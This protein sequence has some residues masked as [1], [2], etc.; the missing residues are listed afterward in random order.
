M[1]S[2][3]LT[4]DQFKTI[5]GYSSK[6]SVA[7][8][9]GMVDALLTEHGVQNK[10]WITKGGVDQLLFEL[11]VEIHG[12]KRVL[13]FKFQPTMIFV[14]KKKGGRYGPIELVEKPTASW[15]V[16]HDLLQR[17]LA[18]ARLGMMPIHHILMSFIVKSL[19]DGTE[20]TFGDFMDLVLE[21]QPGLEGLQLEY[22]KNPKIIEA[23]V[24]E[25]T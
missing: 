9:K 5:P 23:E 1:K 24:T 11:D 15:R 14:K 21:R 18:A 6:L 3:E 4:M 7:R 2:V 20:G 16:F 19:P 22:K 12:V 17:T 10:A 25:I 8:L 13:A